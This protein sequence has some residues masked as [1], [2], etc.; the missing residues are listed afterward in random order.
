MEEWYEIGPYTKGAAENTAPRISC[1]GGICVGTRRAAQVPRA[2]LAQVPPGRAPTHATTLT[3]EECGPNPS[4]L[5]SPAGSL[6][7]LASGTALWMASSWLLSSSISWTFSRLSASLEP[8]F[9]SLASS[10][11]SCSS[12]DSGS[13]QKRCLMCEARMQTTKMPT[14]MMHSTPEPMCIQRPNISSTPMRTRMTPRPY[15]SKSNIWTRSC[16]MKNVAR[17]PN[18][19]RTLELNPMYWFGICATFALTLSKA[20]MMSENST[21]TITTKS[22][23]NFSLPVAWSQTSMRVPCSS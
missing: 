12:S 23:D 13:G 2:G 6:P 9:P 21:M 11:T 8:P 14:M 3:I 4:P 22:N 19:A 16:T 7:G 10:D 20:K 15:A 18:M 17:R 5:V 1:A